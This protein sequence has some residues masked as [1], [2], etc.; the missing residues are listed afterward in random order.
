MRWPACS[1]I[2]LARTVLSMPLSGRIT[3]VDQVRFTDGCSGGPAQEL[4]PLVQPTAMDPAVGCRVAP[5][6]TSA[7][8]LV[9]S[10]PGA[11]PARFVLGQLAD[12]IAYGSGGW[13][14]CVRSRT[15]IPVR[16]VISFVPPT[17]SHADPSD[18]HDALEAHRSGRLRP[19]R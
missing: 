18:D 19:L 13:L 9:E 1:L 3:W 2:I 7:H 17:K 5:T 10:P 14:G 11:G 15:V 8:D 4:W 6:R 12:D 16:P